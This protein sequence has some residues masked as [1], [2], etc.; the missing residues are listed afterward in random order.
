MTTRS[1]E[2]VLD[3]LERLRKRPAS[4]GANEKW[5]IAALYLELASICFNEAATAEDPDKAESLRRMSQRYLIEAE[6]IL[7]ELERLPKR[8]A[9]GGANKKW[10]IAALYLELGIHCFN[11]AR[12]H[13]MP[14]PRRC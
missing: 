1:A 13:W 8:P 10:E 2:L 12:Q 4:C 14:I 5:E 9:S 11:E 7:D 6:L 3:E